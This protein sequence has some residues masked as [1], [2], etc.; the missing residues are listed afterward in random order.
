MSDYNTEIM[1]ARQ[2]DEDSAE[3]LQ[4]AID[5]RAVELMQH[6]ESCDPMD[7]FNVIEAMG[8]ATNNET[9][10]LGHVL[11]RREF[12]QAGILLNQVSQAYWSKKANEQ[13]E[14]ELS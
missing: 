11:A 9:I 3:A 5:A 4:D 12:V 8:E 10:V 13:A 7:G 14:E 1:H 6:G 2:A